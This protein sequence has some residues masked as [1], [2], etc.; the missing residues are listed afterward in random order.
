MCAQ[1]LF[2][3]WS[4]M[5]YHTIVY[6]SLPAPHVDYAATSRQGSDLELRKKGGM[7]LIGTQGEGE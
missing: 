7:P 4:I 6:S 3:L 2:G 1:R 5:Q